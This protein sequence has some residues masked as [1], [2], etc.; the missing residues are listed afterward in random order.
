MAATTG[1][2]DQVMMFQ[3]S[4]N[5]DPLRQQSIAGQHPTQRFIMSNRTGAASHAP[6]HEVSVMIEPRMPDPVTNEKAHSHLGG[7]LSL[8]SYPILV[9]MPCVG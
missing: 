8:R 3:A 6:K 2:P 5:S 1:A 4:S 7:C 9:E